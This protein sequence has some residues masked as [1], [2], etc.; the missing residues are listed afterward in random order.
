MH[1]HITRAI[2]VSAIFASGLTIT[3]GIPAQ[4][5]GSDQ[6]GRPVS[7]SESLTTDVSAEINDHGDLVLLLDTDQDGDPERALHGAPL[8]AE[9]LTAAMER[10]ERADGPITLRFLSRTTV[11]FS[12]FEIV[13]EEGNVTLRALA[14]T[15]QCYPED[16]QTDLWLNGLA[17]YSLSNFQPMAQWTIKGLREKSLVQNRE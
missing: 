13:G 2:A 3:V 4:P 15:P 9:E 10:F 11:A 7:E 17:H 8:N 14:G 5:T 16:S 12:G 6:C 1:H